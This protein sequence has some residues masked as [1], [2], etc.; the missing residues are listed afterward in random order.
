[1]PIKRWL[2]PEEHPQKVRLLAEEY[3]I[4]PFLSRVLVG[5][6]LDSPAKAGELLEC[7]GLS[8]PFALPD[9]RSAVER[10]RLAM[11][12][13]ERVAVYGDYDCD[14]I[15]STVM[16][17]R[18]FRSVGM[19]TVYYVPEREEGYG[20]HRA[21]VQKLKEQGV[22]L[23]VTVDN[24]ISALEEIGF[25]SSLG[26]D[27]IVTDH[28]Q[29]GEELPEAV[30]VVDAHRRDSGAPFRLFCGAGV[31][32][33]LICA[34]EGQQVSGLE[35]M[36]LPLAAVA[37][38]G[39]VVDLVSENRS[40]VVKGLECLASCRLPGLLALLEAAGLSGKKVTSENVAF[41]LVPR[42]N[43][44]GRMGRA[45]LA[46]D[47]LMADSSEQAYPLACSLNDLNT[48]RQGQ[49]REIM[50]Q[51]SQQLSRNPEKLYQRV[52]VLSGE[53]WNH[54]VVGIA[55]SRVLEQYGKPNVLLSVEGGTAVGSARSVGGF[56]LYDALC[57]CSSLLTKFGGHKLAAGM[58]L[59]A[60]G[61]S[62]FEEAI[63]RYAGE[64]FPEMP[65]LEYRADSVLLPEELTLENAESL[66]YLE[67]FGAGNPSPLF[68]MQ[69]ARIQ[70]IVPLSGNRHLKLKLQAGQRRF[71]AL[72][73]GMGTATFPYSVG[74]EIDLLVSLDVNEFRGKR[75]VSVKIKDI[76]P[77][78]LDVEQYL[79]EKGEY[80]K[81]KRGE[82]MLEHY[83]RR[84]LPAREEV[85]VIYRFLHAHAGFQGDLDM[86]Y[87]RPGI[88]ALGYGKYRAALDVLE[89]VGL[90]T[91]SAAD[92]RIELLPVT[93]KVSLDSAPT[94]QKLKA[95]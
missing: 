86:L 75:T 12:K 15:C 4:S 94:M 31:A 91:C 34:L 74:Q 84:F 53:G 40:I 79:C 3:C 72:Q 76:H 14:G 30:A 35:T 55:S 73:F 70:E 50:A 13:G 51:I 92:G 56:S 17:V 23:I 7:P 69:N 87:I 89:E 20:M 8:D 88:S 1:M 18:Y 71:E 61:L 22:S 62:G 85:A 67:P 25:A 83:L 36:Y 82:P 78:G 5:R 63:N 58:Q 21:A 52:L 46:V 37:T 9:M 19:D 26:I 57:S 29:A 32:L 68:L 48:S 66:E 44:A 90:I 77:A 38:V 64:C 49:E 42:I 39:D 16:L 80:E 11:Q 93:K 60:A 45:S 81:L 27:T 6:G 59:P 33:Q 43:A 65:A 95:V 54:G 2:I 28:H 10:I 41:G 47:L 24:G